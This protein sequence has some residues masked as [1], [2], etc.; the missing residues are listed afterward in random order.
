MQFNS[1]LFIII[2]IQFSSV[3]V[4]EHA[5]VTTQ[6][7]ITKLARVRRRTQKTNKQNTK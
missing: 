5:S 7:A 4:Y 3:R 6:R 2:I 1:L